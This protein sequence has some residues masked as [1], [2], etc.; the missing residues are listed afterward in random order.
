V[1]KP[2][3]TIVEASSGNTGNALSMV[4]AVKGYQMLAIMPNGPSRERSPSHGPSAPKS[5]SSEIF[6]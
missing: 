6:M 4:A 1:L 2:G 5:A 3:D